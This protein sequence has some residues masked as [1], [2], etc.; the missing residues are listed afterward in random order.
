MRRPLSSNPAPA[1]TSSAVEPHSYTPPVSSIDGTSR[2]TAS[3]AVSVPN[4]TLNKMPPSTQG[5]PLTRGLRFHRPAIGVMN[6]SA[7]VPSA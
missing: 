7:Y 2:I 3:S 1:T 6:S 5:L 4:A